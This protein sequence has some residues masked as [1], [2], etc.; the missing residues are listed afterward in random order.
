MKKIAIL[1]LTVVTSMANAQ[2]VYLRS[3]GTNTC[4]DALANIQKSPTYKSIYTAYL[5]GYIS[6]HNWNQSTLLTSTISSKTMEQ[7]WIA[8]CSQVDNITKIFTLIANEII[9]EAK[10]KKE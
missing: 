4:G 1:L 5:D 9:E 7:L 8:K 3:W 2:S 10:R 6:Q